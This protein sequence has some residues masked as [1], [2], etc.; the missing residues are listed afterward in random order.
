MQDVEFNGALIPGVQHLMNSLYLVDFEVLKLSEK[1]DQEEE[2]YK[3]SNPRTVTQAGEAVILDKSHCNYMQDSIATKG[4]LNP[5]LAR[6]VKEGENYVPYLV[7]GERRYRAIARL[8]SKKDM[9]R[10][11]NSAKFNADLNRYEYSTRSADEVYAKVPVQI[12]FA[13]DD[14]E[15][16]SYAY[17][18]NDCR[19]NLSEGHDVAMLIQLR[20]AKASDERILSILHKKPQW[21][22][23]TDKLI[24]SL[25]STT[26]HDWIEGSIA[27]E[28]AV[29]LAKVKDVETRLSC[30]SEAKE[31]SVIVWQEKIEKIQQ[32]VESFEEEV[33]IAE[34]AEAI[35]EVSGD[36]ESI[37]EAIEQKE[38]AKTKLDHAVK[39]RETTKPVVKSKQARAAINN[40][41]GEG[42]T[43]K[44][45]R[46]PKIRKHYFEYLEK[47]IASDGIDDEIQV[48]VPTLNFAFDLVKGI[49]EGET[50]VSSILKTHQEYL[51]AMEEDEEEIQGSPR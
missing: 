11:T 51:E 12:Y 45:L 16:L 13:S 38:V 19:V 31:A 43:N 1:G 35:A 37:G 24:A 46:G 29:E 15:A 8:K 9:V 33:E 23:D 21:L 18:E 25:D 47:I 49:L 44:C 2:D 39:T 40:Q 22:R 50:T 36:E 34:S 26:L 3:F 41:T 32:Q 10:D 5:L 4:L 17:D 30:L 48:P 7:G 28:A 42:E 6:W 27:R 14:L 20:Q